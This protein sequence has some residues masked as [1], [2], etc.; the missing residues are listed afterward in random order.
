MTSCEK[1]DGF[2]FEEKIV[3]N[4][5]FEQY[6]F[7]IE[8]FIKKVPLKDVRIFTSFFPCILSDF[9]EAVCGIIFFGC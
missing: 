9:F 1:F 7:K 3:G 5:F 4:K 2:F 8:V 6:F